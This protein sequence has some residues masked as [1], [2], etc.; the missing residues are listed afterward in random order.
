[1]SDFATAQNIETVAKADA[2]P[3]SFKTS[4]YKLFIT[5]HSKFKVD[6][7]RQSIYLQ[8]K[9]LLKAPPGVF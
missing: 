5:D 7:D 6:L 8:K 9:S 1:M 2:T 4:D 3:L